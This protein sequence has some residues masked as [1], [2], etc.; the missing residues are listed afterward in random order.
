MGTIL[1]AAQHTGHRAKSEHR[2][3]FVFRGQTATFSLFRSSLEEMP[4]AAERGWRPQTLFVKSIRL[5]CHRR[6]DI[7]PLF[8]TLKVAGVTGGRTHTSSWAGRSALGVRQLQA[9]S[10]TSPSRRSCFVGRA[11]YQDGVNQRR[12]CT[13]ARLGC[14]GSA[15]A[16]H[17]EGVKRRDC[18]VD[19]PYTSTQ[20]RTRRDGWAGAYRFDP[21][22]LAL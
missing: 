22:P 15:Q 14:H 4:Q 7:S 19:M 12:C 13:L 6:C 18:E 17:S 9:D 20:H 16:C 10:V 21:S 11:S 5:S 1:Y 3:L 2:L 8:L